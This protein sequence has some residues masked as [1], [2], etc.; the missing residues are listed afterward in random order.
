METAYFTMHPTLGITGVVYA[1]STEKARTTFLDWLERNGHIKRT[2]R[3]AF[4]KNMGAQR[5][6]DTNVP[7]DVVLH[8]GY[9]EGAPRSSR[10]IIEDMV[11]GDPKLEEDLAL[12][13]LI[14]DINRS[15]TLEGLEEEEEDEPGPEPIEPPGPKLMPVQQIMLRG[16]TQ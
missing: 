10:A 5:L 6:D 7:S 8:Y 9:A 2:D 15:K 4:R 11:K 1:P 13:D 3:Q 14:T 16:F 12:T